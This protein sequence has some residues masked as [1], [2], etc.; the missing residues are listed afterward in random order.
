MFS[1]F[2]FEECTAPRVTLSVNWTLGDDGV[3]VWVHGSPSVVQDAGSTGGC[4][5]RQEVLW[6][7]F[8]LSTQF[9][10]NLKLLLR[11]KT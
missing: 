6:K 1:L 8:I 9:A 7:L 4:V 5:W 3:S 10:V 11:N 2:T